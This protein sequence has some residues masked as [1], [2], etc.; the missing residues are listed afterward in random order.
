VSEAGSRCRRGAS[1]SGGS[2]SRTHRPGG[3]GRFAAVSVDGRRLHATLAPTRSLCGCVAA[4]YA[5]RPD[6]ELQARRPP[7][8][9]RHSRLRREHAAAR[10]A[11]LQQG[12]ACRLRSHR[13]RACRQSACCEAAVHGGAP[14][15][16][17]NAPASCP[18]SF[19]FPASSRGIAAECRRDEGWSGGAGDSDDFA[20]RAPTSS[21][22]VP[23]SQQPDAIKH[24]SGARLPR[25]GSIAAEAVPRIAG[26]LPGP[27]SPRARIGPRA[28][29]KGE[30]GAGVPSRCKTAQPAASAHGV[31]EGPKGLGHGDSLPLSR[32]RKCAGGAW[33]TIPSGTLEHSP[34][35]QAA[36]GSRCLFTS[37]SRKA[38]PRRQ[39][40]RCATSVIHQVGRAPSRGESRRAPQRCAHR[41]ALH[42]G[43]SGIAQPPAAALVAHRYSVRGVVV[44]HPDAGRLIRPRHSHPNRHQP[45]QPFTSRCSARATPHRFPATG[46]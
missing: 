41:K 16:R 36:P 31:V 32:P 42:R 19:R 9:K 15:R 26:E 14:A 7:T 17:V 13:G 24:D 25:A 1:R 11:V 3:G 30:I 18:N 40:G 35:H 33:A 38:S 20:A 23:V 39:P 12:P 5:A 45:L 44:D 10:L 2:V 8:R 37:A 6:A 22:P 27:C 29:G 43:R 34:T 46:S 21:L 28:G 4:D